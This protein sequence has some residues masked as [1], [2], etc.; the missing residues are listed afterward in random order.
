[1]SN[2]PAEF[3]HAF[4]GVVALESEPYFD[5][6]QKK[7]TTRLENVSSELKIAPP[8]RFELRARAGITPHSWPPMHPAW[9]RCK[10]FIYLDDSLLAPRQTGALY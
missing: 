10:S 1:M 3:T 8:V 5:Q 7:E 4:A 6:D 2:F 9:L